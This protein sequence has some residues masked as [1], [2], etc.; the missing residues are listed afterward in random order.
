ML[1]SAIEYT[2]D[3]VFG[4]QLQI[5][6]PDNKEFYVKIGSYGGE[7]EQKKFEQRRQVQEA[8]AQTPKKVQF[9]SLKNRKG[10][11]FFKANFDYY[12]AHDYF[13]PAEKSKTDDNNIVNGYD[14]SGILNA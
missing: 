2:C 8:Q 7:S 14:Y 1:T 3:Y 9:V 10:K 6:D 5:L 11:Q 12:P 13:R 4:L